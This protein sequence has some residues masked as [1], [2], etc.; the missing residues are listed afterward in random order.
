MRSNMFSLLTLAI[1]FGGC[2]SIPYSWNTENGTYFYKPDKEACALGRSTNNTDA[3]IQ[4]VLGASY[5]DSDLRNDFDKCKEIHRI[6]NMY[7]DNFD[8]G[9][10]KLMECMI[11]RGWALQSAIK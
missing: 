5:D 1:C 4:C 11:S 7:Y 3:N 2:T 8:T 9:N 10:R 6:K